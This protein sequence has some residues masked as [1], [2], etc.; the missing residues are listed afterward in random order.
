MAAYT[1]A[2]ER[3][4]PQASALAPKQVEM[5]LRRVPAHVRK[6]F[7]RLCRKRNTTMTHALIDYMRAEVLR[8]RKESLS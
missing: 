5:H 8:D 7:L 4:R 2:P 3:I 1:P 6:N